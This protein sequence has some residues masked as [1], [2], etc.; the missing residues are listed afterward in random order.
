M[1]AF[2]YI[3]ALEFYKELYQFCPPNWVETFFI[4][5]NFAFIE[6]K[7]AMNENF[8]AFFPDLADKKNNPFSE[9][10]GYFANPRGPKARVASLGGQ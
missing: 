8:F 4:E 5:S 2:F 7:V 6:G 9:S 3:E 10:T 1:L